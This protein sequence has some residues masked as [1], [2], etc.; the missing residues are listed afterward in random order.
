[1]SY[2]IEVVDI[3]FYVSQTGQ[4]NIDGTVYLIKKKMTHQHFALSL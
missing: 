3:L 1:M 2:Y 4:A